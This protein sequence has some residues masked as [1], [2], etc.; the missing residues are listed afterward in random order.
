MSHC[1]TNDSISIN[2]QLSRKMCLK[3]F[4]MLNTLIKYTSIIVSEAQQESFLRYL[5]I[6]V[7]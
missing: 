2:I 6:D 1:N 7:N 3:K 4:V 5:T